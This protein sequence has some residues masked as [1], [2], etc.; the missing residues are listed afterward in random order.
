MDRAEYNR[1]SSRLNQTIIETDTVLGRIQSAWCR[2]VR[3]DFEN[4]GVLT[5]RHSLFELH[6]FLSG[7]GTAVLNN[8]SDTVSPAAA[9]TKNYPIG[10]G[11]F[12]L[13]PPM[14]D[15]ALLNIAPESA[16]FVMAFSADNSKTYSGGCNV[17]SGTRQ[18]E[19]IIE[20]MQDTALKSDPGADYSLCALAGVLIT[21][22][23]RI[24]CP[25]LFGARRRKFI[26]EE[27]LADYAEQIIRDN[28]DHG[29]TA[30]FVSAQM[31]L[32]LKQL[33]R[34]TQK[35]RGLSVSQLIQKVR[36]EVIK[37][38]LFCGNET[39]TQIAEKTGFSSEYSLS[40]FFTRSQG[41][42]PGRYRREIRK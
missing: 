7:G 17:L 11:E 26:K 41:I 23:L 40:R 18:M 22:A 31:F 39:M 32:S 15:H 1:S 20:M 21:D 16:K 14:T 36:L 28:I 24:A 2:I 29:I 6:Y 4:M 19:T 33:N 30:E 25:S 35:R 12:L 37:Q 38:L 27:S 8:G 3:S 34:I 13:V 9:G 5:H 42:S 10:P